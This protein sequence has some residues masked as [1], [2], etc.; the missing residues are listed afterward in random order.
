MALFVFYIHSPA[1][2]VAAQAWKSSMKKNILEK[3][4]PYKKSKDFNLQATFGNFLGD[5]EMES[6]DW[7]SFLWSNYSNSKSVVHTVL[8]W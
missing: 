2:S 6:Q 8:S 5:R 3:N 7:S 4:W 1:Y